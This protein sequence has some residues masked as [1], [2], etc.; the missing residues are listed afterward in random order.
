MNSFYPFIQK[1]I[2]EKLRW[3]SDEDI[4]NQFMEEMDGIG[5]DT[6]T[7]TQ[8]MENYDNL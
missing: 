2:C 8:T 5:Y 3:Q 6:K 4:T 7:L 1:V